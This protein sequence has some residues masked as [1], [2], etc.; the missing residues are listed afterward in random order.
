[1]NPALEQSIEGWEEKLDECITDIQPALCSR[2]LNIIKKYLMN[3]TNDQKVHVFRI[4]S[5]L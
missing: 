5:L 3:R 1:L 2:E 4:I